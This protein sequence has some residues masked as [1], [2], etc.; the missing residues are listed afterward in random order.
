MSGA[1]ASPNPGKESQE[2]EDAWPNVENAGFRTSG[3]VWTKKQTAGS[4]GQTA[5]S[6]A[7]LV[8]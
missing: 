4:A 5:R 1:D 2:A 3:V 6:G 7:G 8:L